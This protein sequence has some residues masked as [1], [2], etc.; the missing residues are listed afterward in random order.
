MHRIALR[1]PS[2]L[3]LGAMKLRLASGRGG[4]LDLATPRVRHEDALGRLRFDAGRFGP[5][6]RAAVLLLLGSQALHHL[7][8]VLA[9]DHHA[10]ATL[11][12]HAD[13]WHLL[14]SGPGIAVIC[15]VSVAALVV[16]A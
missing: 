16:R 10:G 6:L 12:G 14:A 7:R 1:A 3:C 4:A 11:A 2:R 5:L 15:A 9:P 8:Y 13:A